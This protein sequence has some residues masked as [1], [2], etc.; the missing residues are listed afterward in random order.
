M[1][2]V[3]VLTASSRP[4]GRLARIF[5]HTRGS[6]FGAIVATDDLIFEPNPA[7][8]AGLFDAGTHSPLPPLF[9]RAG[10]STLALYP[11]LNAW[12]TCAK[13]LWYG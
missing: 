6:R 9:I 12:A 4:I 1:L 2:P 13:I 5:H 7:S 3:S 8:Q 10:D 11:V